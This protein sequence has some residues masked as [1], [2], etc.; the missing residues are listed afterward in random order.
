MDVHRA[1]AE[2]L[3]VPW[4]MCDVVWGDTSKNL[5]FSCVSGGSQTTHAMTRASYAVAQ[6]CK[7]R[8][9]EVAAKSL[10]GQPDQYEVGNQRVFRK[11]GGGGMTLA[12]AAQHAIE[13]GG[14][15][16]GHEAPADVHK[17]T[18]N[19]VAALAGQ[20]LVASAKDNYPRDGDTYS[21]VASFAEVEVDVET[22]KYHIVDFLA[23]G[24]VGTV[25]HPHAL[26]G[27]VL[28][29][30]TLGMGACDLARSGYSIPITA[31]W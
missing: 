8:L 28:G 23:Y 6:E 13:L 24:D 27:Q 25:I 4:E 14:I 30:S 17:L 11:G 26:S 19:S 1:G 7:T 31:S 15:Y 29:R 21:F 18:K 3:G 20:G 22:G 12:Q 5:P 10:G 9:Q 2:V 16:D